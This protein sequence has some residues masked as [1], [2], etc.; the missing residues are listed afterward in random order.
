MIEKLCSKCKCKKKKFCFQ[1]DE[2]NKFKTY[3]NC[4]NA[5]KKYYDKNKDDINRKRREERACNGN[6][7]CECGLLVKPEKWD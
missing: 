3:Q 4:R 7:K 2:K 6:I 5:R 1:D